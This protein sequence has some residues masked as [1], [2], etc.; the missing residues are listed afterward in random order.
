MFRPNLKFV[1]LLVPE[2]TGDTPKIG[3]SLDTL[4]LPF[5]QNFNGL[6]AVVRVDPVN[7][8]A[9]FEDRIASPVP[10]IIA[11]GVLG[12]S[13]EP[14]N[15]GEEEAVEGRGWYRSKERW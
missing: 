10:G 4:T 13:C 12:G 7:V 9:K 15:F 1:A 8:L 5:L 3:Q 6:L 14:P 2:I 11:I